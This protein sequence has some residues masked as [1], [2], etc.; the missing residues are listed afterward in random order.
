VDVAAGAVV[1]IAC[2]ESGFSGTNLL[3]PANPV[4]THASVDL[5]VGE[6]AEP[7]AA[8]RSGFR[9]SLNEFKSARF[10]RGPKAGRRWSGSWRR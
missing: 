7:L 8:L 1:E 3:H 2:D 6:A 10:L 4:I 9:C 5:C